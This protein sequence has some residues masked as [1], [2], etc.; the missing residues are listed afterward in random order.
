MCRQS[1]D[2]NASWMNALQGRNSMNVSQDLQ[3]WAVVIPRNIK[4]QSM[5]FIKMM[6][7]VSKGMRFNVAEPEMLVLMFICTYIIQNKPKSNLLKEKNN[8][9]YFRIHRIDIND[10]RTNS[11]STELQNLCQKNLQ[12]VMVAISSNSADR[13]SAIKKVRAQN[14]SKLN[15]F[16]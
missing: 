5:G 14:I 11:L 1:A 15:H 12:M 3:R 4:S 8:T 16:N 7:E 9:K 13:Y 2:H 6:M 10:D